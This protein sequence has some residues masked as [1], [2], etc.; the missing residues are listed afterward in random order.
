MPYADGTCRDCGWDPQPGRSRCARCL[1]ARREHQAQ[2]IAERLAAGLCR[3][4]A[5]PAQEGSHHCRTHLAYYRAR[6]RAVVRARRAAEGFA[7]RMDRDS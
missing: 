4:C 5:A 3:V 7:A 6:W 1:R 2:V